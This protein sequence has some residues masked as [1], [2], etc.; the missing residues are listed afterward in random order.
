MGL[1][2][3]FRSGTYRV[4]RKGGAVQRA[5][6]RALLARLEVISGASTNLRLLR[7]FEVKGGT[8]Y[9][10]VETAFPSTT[11]HREEAAPDRRGA[12]AQRRA[13]SGGREERQGQ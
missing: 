10:R 2:R 3:A 8:S 1:K 5:E 12:E 11:L 13:L 4:L 7:A 9:H 6:K